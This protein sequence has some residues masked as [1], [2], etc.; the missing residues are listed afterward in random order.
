MACVAR[1][2]IH[3]CTPHITH[4][5]LSLSAPSLN[6]PPEQFECGAIKTV[7]GAGPVTA[8]NVQKLTLIDHLHVM[9]PCCVHYHQLQFTYA[10]THTRTYECV[11]TFWPARTVKASCLSFSFQ[12]AHS[13]WWFN[14]S[15][16]K[17][18]RRSFAIHN[19]KKKSQ[20]DIICVH[21]F[22]AS[23]VT[24][25]KTSGFSIRYFY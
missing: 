11:R 3:H 7:A 19:K 9:P 12:F 22:R 1:T 8:Q 25:S 17:V 21:H 16:T 4:Y 15:S 14:S 18:P 13:E 6:Q 23:A 20:V 24:T 2:L 5:T 10:Y